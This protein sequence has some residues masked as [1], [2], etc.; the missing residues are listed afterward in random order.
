[1][2]L[3]VHVSLGR[4][5]I[6]LKLKPKKAWVFIARGECERKIAISRTKPKSSCWL[7]MI[8]TSDFAINTGEISI[9]IHVHSAYE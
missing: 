4:E 7:K 5:P 8:Y 1:M 3:H 9:C 2:W 6:I